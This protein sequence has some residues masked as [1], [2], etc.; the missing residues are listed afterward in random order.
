MTDE[1]NADLNEL[2]AE[3]AEALGLKIEPGNHA[4]VPRAVVW[5]MGQDARADERAKLLALDDAIRAQIGAAG[6]KKPAIYEDGCGGRLTIE[7]D[8]NLIVVST[9]LT[10][11]GP[12]RSVEAET[13]EQLRLLQIVGEHLA[14]TCAVLLEKRG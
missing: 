6:L 11:G 4:A 5:R 12:V 3:G 10:V 2:I 1:Q 13:D 8:R 7:A 9:M 14:A